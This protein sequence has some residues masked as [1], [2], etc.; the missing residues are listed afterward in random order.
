[1]QELGSA[2]P[3]PMQI[4]T[5]LLKSP[6]P[7]C[8]VTPAPFSTHPADAASHSGQGV[9]LGDSVLWIL[10]WLLPKAAR[11][12][13][14]RLCFYFPFFLSSDLSLRDFLSVWLFFFSEYVTCCWEKT[15]CDSSVVELFSA[16]LRSL[17]TTCRMVCVCGEGGGFSIQVM[18]HGAT[19]P[20]TTNWSLG[21]R[22][23]GLLTPLSPWKCHEVGDAEWKG[24]LQHK[25][26]LT[27][28]Y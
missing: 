25:P 13:W 18:L 10:P 16:S 14:C 20:Q 22:R 2:G 7:S 6:T 8:C 27:R 5:S 12:L 26:S 9:E 23:T 4:S 17:K 1:M 28:L 19:V 11:A 24:E 3:E 21:G 15:P